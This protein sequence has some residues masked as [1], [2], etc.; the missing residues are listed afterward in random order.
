MAKRPACVP[1]D[2]GSTG[3]VL[4]LVL[5]LVVV[6]V[7]LDDVGVLDDGINHD[8]GLNGLKATGMARASVVIR[9][10]AR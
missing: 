4:V 10:G 6:V 9:L 2:V 1:R 8:H 7:V 5:V 3:V